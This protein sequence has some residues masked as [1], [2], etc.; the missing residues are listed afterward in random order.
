MYHLSIFKSLVDWL[1]KEEFCKQINI[2]IDIYVFNDFNELYCIV[3]IYVICI[4][5]LFCIKYYEYKLNDCCTCDECCV[6]VLKL[7]NPGFVSLLSTLPH[8]I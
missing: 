8:G 1:I 5:F 7:W 6:C 3:L 2:C 4:E